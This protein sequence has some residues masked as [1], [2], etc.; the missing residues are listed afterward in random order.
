[1]S[2]ET[3]LACPSCHEIAEPDDT[4][5]E[6]CGL[7]LKA[8]MVHP[9]ETPVEVD[10]GP[11]AGV[12]DRGAVRTENQ[13]AFFVA[14]PAGGAVAVVCDGVSRSSFPDRAAAAAAEAAGMT[15]E[16]RLVAREPADA[17]NPWA[18]MSDAVEDAREAAAGIPWEGPATEPPASTFVAGLWDGECVT[19]CSVGDSRAYWLGL[20]ETVQLTTDDTWTTD[21]NDPKHH[22]VTRWFGPD[23]PDDAPKITSFRPGEPGLLILCSDGLWGYAPSTRA[24]GAIVRPRLPQT[25]LEVARGL[26]AYALASGGGD[27]VTVVVVDTARTRED[28]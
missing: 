10:L 9:Q 11:I 14:A 19:V 20:T 22:T 12:S 23:A 16:A 25:A 13:D 8:A 21:L 17:W 27:N 18:V 15:L 7:R 2:G 5:C 26:V 4:F 28:R 1:M 6:A 24:L 3:I